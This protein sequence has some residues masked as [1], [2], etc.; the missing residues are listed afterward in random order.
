MSRAEDVTL[1][2]NVNRLAN[3][4]GSVQLA[5]KRM[6]EQLSRPQDELNA[7]IAVV[8]GEI[9]IHFL[10]RTLIAVPRPVVHECDV[11]LEYTFYDEARVEAPAVWRF[12]LQEGRQ[13]EFSVRTSLGPEAENTVCDHNNQYVGLFILRHVCR[14]LLGSGLFDPSGQ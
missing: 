14:S 10:G 9:R 8:E 6:E 2:N 4:Y 1:A 13:N 11:A 3:S 5:R 12:Y 7:Q